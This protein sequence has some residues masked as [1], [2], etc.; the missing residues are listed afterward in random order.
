MSSPLQPSLALLV[1]TTAQRS[2]YGDQGGPLVLTLHEIV[3]ST[4]GPMLGAG[5]LL[6]TSE[7]KSLGAVLSD[8]A[9]AAS[10]REI[11]LLPEYLLRETA[12]SLT[13]F[14]PPTRTVQHWRTQEGR[15]V[16]EAVLPGL[17]FHV[18]EGV[19][20]VAAF[21]GHDRPTLR[22]PLFH[23]PLGNVHDDFR[24]CTGNA[25]LPRAFD[26]STTRA[27]EAV[28]LSTC[29]THINHTLVLAGGATTEQLIA[30]WTKRKRY[31]TPP[32]TK[33][34]APTRY[35]LGDFLVATAKASA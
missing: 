29:Y 6:S 23:A 5:R 10:R 33:L 35:T 26:A 14:R 19:L 9:K 31:A 8:P 1:H 27:W 7:A 15:L 20:H 22:T 2:S 18:E 11:A 24:I 12:N 13:W 28:L 34:M 3:G 16:I 17:V 30:F 32:D 4:H 25:V 21:G